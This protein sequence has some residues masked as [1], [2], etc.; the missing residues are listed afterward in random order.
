MTSTTLPSQPAAASKAAVESA[1]KE[2][3]NEGASTSSNADAS[4]MASSDQAGDESI[5]T[6]FD[7]K[8]DFNVKHPLYN[9]WTLWFDN[10]S[11]K[12]ASAA[13]GSKDSWG[14]DLNK[15]VTFDSVEEFWGLY[16][17]IIPPSELPQKAN[18][19]LFKEG[20]QPAWEDPANANGGKWSIQL[21]RD[22]SRKDIDKLW[23]YTMLSAIGETLETTPTSP[24]SEDLSELITGVIMSAR[25]NFYRI[26]IWT[27][28]S[29][30]PAS[31]PGGD[32]AAVQDVVKRLMAIGQKFKT[33]ILG[34]APEQKLGGQGLM[35]DVEYQSHTESEKKKGRKITV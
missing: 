14:E 30:D 27:R 16:N 11:H 9:V 6:V 28:K 19:Y 18:Y 8:E 24:N 22:K 31:V 10:P 26:A 35:T 15:V 7:D 20:I 17:N 32:A 23:L 21:P 12:N 1:I 4:E 33:E 13:K 34:F 2:S 3:V 29:D 5:R 25:S